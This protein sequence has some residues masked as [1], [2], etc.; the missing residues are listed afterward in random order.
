MRSSRAPPQLH[1]RYGPG[2]YFSVPLQ[3]VSGTRYRATIPGA[4]CGESP[5]YYATAEGVTTGVRAAP[6]TG[7]FSFV[8]GALQTT[9]VAQEGFGAGLPAG[10]TATGL[11]H[12]SLL[13]A[14]APACE[15]APWMVYNQDATCNYST[16]V[17][18]S[19][20][21]TMP[22]ISLPSVPAGG[23]VTLTYCSS[24]ETESGAT[25]DLHLVFAN[26]T[27]VDSPS[28]GP[29]STRTVDLTGLAGQSV[30]LRWE[31]N[32]VDSVANA[33]RGWQVDS[34]AITATAA[35]CQGRCLADFDRNGVVEPADIAGFVSAWSDGVSQ[36]SAAADFDRNGVCEPADI[37]QFINAW[38]AALSGS[39]P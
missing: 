22:A 18:N 8:V 35:T 3:I 17:T 19:G 26:T 1:Y 25:Y 7:A 28:Q 13:C 29:W 39:C 4:H 9:P 14:V 20:S 24:V 15:S 36:G 31:F 12:S 16:G 38:F 27:V 23:S 11:W 37:G 34:V 2:P 6:G 33:F 32:T 5:Q 10:W 30:T 21:L